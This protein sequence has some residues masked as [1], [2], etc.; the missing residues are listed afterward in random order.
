MRTESRVRP[1]AVVSV[2]SVAMTFGSIVGFVPGFIATALRA[3]LGID[4][5]HV[6]LL[7]GLHY[8]CTG[9]GSLPAGRITDRW[10]ARVVVVADLVLVTLAAALAAA[11][12]SYPALLVAAVLSGSG[13]ALTN[14][15]TNVAVV[16]AVSPRWR[17]LAMVAKMAAIPGFSA[18]IA[19]GGPWVSV[20]WGWEWVLGALAV[21]AAVV[22]LAAFR[23]LPDDRPDRRGDLDRR[24]PKHF[25][26]FPVAA[27][28]LVAGSMP[29]YAWSVPYLEESLGASSTLSG[30]LVGV[31]V[32]VGA[33][34]MI[35]VGLLADRMGPE[36][37]IR[38]VM[39]LSVSNPVTWVL[40]G[41]VRYRV[42]LVMTL[43][44]TLGVFIALILAGGTF[45]VGVAMV[46]IIGG[47][48]LQVA[49]IGAMHAAVVDRAG[50]AVARATA[51]TA[52][53]YYLAALV[54]P[55]MFGAFVDGGGSYGWAWFIACML[56][57]GAAVAFRLAGRLPPGAGAPTDPAAVPPTATA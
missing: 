51:V 56:L 37:R 40:F 9:L 43:A 33:G 57:V 52:T 47:I 32:A 16:R 41:F 38:L 48:S 39:A 14:V 4:R 30:V 31:A 10:G 8:G 42:R 2:S 28:L 53:G 20:R 27:F 36:Q 35:V 54:S 25:G 55:V 21:G 18:L 11:L 49:C 17:T 13:Y 45:G 19:A 7:M 3:D 50:P 22:A 46:G 29:L 1:L 26:W 6:G 34:V 24:L 12:G 44:M 5:W 23:V 15:G